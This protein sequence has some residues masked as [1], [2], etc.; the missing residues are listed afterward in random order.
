MSLTHLG[1]TRM[2]VIFTAIREELARVMYGLG[3][4]GILF[5]ALVARLTERRHSDPKTT[6]NSFD[7]ARNQGRVKMRRHATNN[8]PWFECEQSIAR[9]SG[10]R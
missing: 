6:W 8:L 2:R 7:K 10:H 4:I 3:T 9:L 5:L 1:L